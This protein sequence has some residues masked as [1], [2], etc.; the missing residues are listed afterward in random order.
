MNSRSYCIDNLR[1]FLILLLVPYHTSMAWNVWGEPNYVF[2][3]G[4]REIS[5]FI[6]FLSPFFM[7]VLFLLAGISASYSLSKRTPREYLFERVKRLL[8]P[9]IFGTVVFMPV[10]AFLADRFNYSYDG[11]FLAHYAVFFTKFT[12]LTGAD[13][14][15]SFGQFWFLI[16]LFVIS[17]I[18][19]VIVSALKGKKLKPLPLWIIVLLGFPLPFLNRLLSVGG[20]SLVEYLYLFLIGFYVFSDGETIIKLEERWPVFLLLGI[21]ASALD[22]YLFIWSDAEYPVL[23]TAAKFV[24]EWCMILGLLGISEK[25]FDKTGIVCRYM[26]SRSF[27]FFSFHFL[28]VVV[29]QYLLYLQFGNQTAVLFLGTIIL[30]YLAS[31]LACEIVDRIPALCFLLG[32]KKRQY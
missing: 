17:A 14:G 4:N 22:V 1:W 16:Y 21:A 18:S 24:S 19:I 2:F 26:S 31:F 3:E 10:M 30:S 5:S 20:K 23:N 9:L 28:F 13:G 8:M 25:F 27:L 6:V 11:S 15:F 7:P 12:D 29:F 32:V